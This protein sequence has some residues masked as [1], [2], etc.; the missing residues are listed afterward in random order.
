MWADFVARV[1]KRFGVCD[2]ASMKLKPPHIPNFRKMTARLREAPV[3]AM[4][5]I[6]TFAEKEAEIFRNKIEN[7]EF[8]SFDATPLSDDWLA[9]KAKH[10]LDLRTMIATKTYVSKIRVFVKDTENGKMV[11]IGFDE[12]DRAVDPV[13][14]ELTPFPLHL[15]AA[16]QEFGSAKANVPARPHWGPQ[17][18][19]IAQ[20]AGGVRLRIQNTVLP[21]GKGK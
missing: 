6:R 12:E 13:T 11:Y 2:I 16:V 1:E 14:K 15:L 4:T 7:Q 18:Q 19:E 9:F 3:V 5:L 17:L 10:N 8:E 20:R 21:T